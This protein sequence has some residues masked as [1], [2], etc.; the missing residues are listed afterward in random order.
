MHTFYTNPIRSIPL[1][2]VSNAFIT[3]PLLVQD[4]SWF[5]DSKAT[6]HVTS[7]PIQLVTTSTYQGND[8]LQVGN[9]ENLIISYT[10]HLSITNF[11]YNKVVH[12]K[13]NICV[14]HITRNLLSI[15]K[16]TKDNNVLV[17]FFADQCVIKDKLS[18][19]VLL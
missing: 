4:G 11:I 18:K 6:N 10:G 2:I 14:P 3:T 19:V 12:L 15:S 7:D 13:N 9:G 17:E 5:M 8:Q 1:V 16:I